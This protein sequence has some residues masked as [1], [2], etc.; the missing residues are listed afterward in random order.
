[1]EQVGS[2]DV[3]A[4]TSARS[5]SPSSLIIGHQSSGMSLHD[6]S[7]F[8]VPAQRTLRRFPLR[9]LEIRRIIK[10]VLR[11]QVLHQRE[12]AAVALGENHHAD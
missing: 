6:T 9:H 5:M 10:R 8:P 11:D 2:C 7:G 3:L 1:M 4:I 12:L